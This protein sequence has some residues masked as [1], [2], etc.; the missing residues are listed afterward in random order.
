VN[1]LKEVTEKLAAKGKLISQIYDEAG[2]D[3][4]FS[5]VK[6]LDGDTTAKVEALKAIDVEV[7]ELREERIKLLDAE[8]TLKFGRELNTEFNQPAPGDG[9][10]THPPGPAAMRKTLGDLVVE[11]K[12]CGELKGREVH[13]DIDLK[14]EMTAAAGWDPPTVRES[15]VELSAQAPI[16]VIDVIPMLTTT[17]DTIKYMKETTFTNNAAETLE[18]GAY[19]EAALALTEQS[20]EVEKIAVFLPVTDE[21]LEDVSALAGYINNRLTYMLRARL[22]GQILTGDGATPNLLGTLNLAALLSQAKGTDPTPDAFYKAMNQVR[23]TGFAEPSVCFIH[24]TDWQSIRLLRT[25]DGI[26]IFGNPMEAGPSRLWGVP[27]VLTTRETQNTGLT[28][29]YRGFSNFYM[30]RGVTLKVTDSHASNF[31]QGVQVIRADMRGAMVHYRD[32]AF[33]S[34]TGI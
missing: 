14:T 1:G 17:R 27:V 10:M 13:L 32:T 23:T 29:D 30:R 15:R 11:S 9:G 8:K 19:G 24:P 12:V 20:D 34:V 16:G 7:T 26:Y 33:C 4:D 6:C 28:G 31:T 18:S 3:L 21:Q 22:D 2:E 25:A 5:K